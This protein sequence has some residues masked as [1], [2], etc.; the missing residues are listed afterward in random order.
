MD[1]G[2]Y[3]FNVLIKGSACE[4]SKGVPIMTLAH[5]GATRTSKCCEGSTGKDPILA[6]T[7]RTT[8]LPFGHWVVRV[9]SINP[10]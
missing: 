7:Q 10:Y 9:K 6:L 5:E 8:K 1:A 3:M 4:G 2:G